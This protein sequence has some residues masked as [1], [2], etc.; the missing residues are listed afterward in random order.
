MFY[1][2]IHDH[3]IAPHLLINFDSPNKP[4]PFNPQFLDEVHT[5]KWHCLTSWQ[6]LEGLNDALCGVTFFFDRT[7]VCNKQKLSV[8]PLMFSLLMAAPTPEPTNTPTPALSPD[9][10]PAPTPSPMPAPTPTLTPE[11]SP[12][13][14]PKSTPAQTPAPSYSHSDTCSY[15]W[16]DPCSYSWPNPT[17]SLT[18][19]LTPNLTPAPTPSPMPAPTP[20]LTPE[21][22]GAEV[23][24]KGVLSEKPP[25]NHF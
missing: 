19:A 10:T 21:K 14:T 15:S 1:D 24:I 20:T 6:F 3:Q 8:H 16:P 7:H 18:P 4:P 5:G 22:E 9:P 2:L 17:T 12:A 23:N 11:P 25:K 13:P